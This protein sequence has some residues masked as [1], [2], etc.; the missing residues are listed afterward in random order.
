M[1]VKSVTIESTELSGSSLS[2]SRASPCIILFIFLM[3]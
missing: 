3:N 2:F 1:K